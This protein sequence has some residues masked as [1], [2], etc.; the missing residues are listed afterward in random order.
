MRKAAN[1]DQQHERNKEIEIV[2][3][4]G[5]TRSEKG[6]E[7]ELEVEYMS[8]CGCVGVCVRPRR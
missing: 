3:D 6:V 8:E 4:G 2:I 5:M 7:R 1:E